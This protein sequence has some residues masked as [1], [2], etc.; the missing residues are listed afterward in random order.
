MRGCIV[1][2]DLATLNLILVKKGNDEIPGFTDEQR[3]RRLGPKRANKIR[4]MFALTKEDDVRKFVVRRELTIGNKKYKAP[5][6]QRLV[7]PERLHRM[8]RT[9]TIRI[10]KLQEHRKDKEEY[11]KLCQKRKAED[12][13]RKAAEVSKKKQAKKKTE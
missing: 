8:K 9:T 7:T 1:G 5:K 13:A 2:L 11:E 10:K 4:K 3:P 6:I 12:K